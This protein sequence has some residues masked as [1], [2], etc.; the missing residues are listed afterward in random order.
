MTHYRIKAWAEYQHYK[1]RSPPWIK[2]HRDLLTSNTWV[3]LDNASRVLAVACMLVAADTDNKIP[4]EP[5]FMRRRAYLDADPVYAPLVEVG[6]LEIVNEIKPLKSKR[7]RL[8]ADAS[9]MQAN[10]TECSSEERRGE[11]EQRREEARAFESFVDAA[12]KFSWP[13]PTQLTD[14]RRKKLGARLKQHGESGWMSALAK[15]QASKFVREEMTSWSFDWFIEAS[16]FAKV[17]EGNYDERK[18]PAVSRGQP[19]FNG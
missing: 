11:T 16:N 19:V 6:F 2:L 14:T 12:K 1:D 9:A 8:L 17:L 4:A 18:A 5:A 15:A 13:I 7:K 10:D 3:M